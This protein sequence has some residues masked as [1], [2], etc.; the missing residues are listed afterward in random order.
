MWKPDGSSRSMGRRYGRVRGFD[1]PR[2]LAAGGPLPVRVSQC[3]AGEA[4]QRAPRSIAHFFPL[5]REELRDPPMGLTSAV[6]SQQDSS[7]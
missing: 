6:R 1:F 2:A 4:Q 3:L 5:L 7:R